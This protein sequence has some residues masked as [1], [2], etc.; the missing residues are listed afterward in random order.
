MNRVLAALTIA[1]ACLAPAASPAQTPPALTVSGE[2]RVA[3]A[4][5]LAALRVGVSAEADEA[6]EAVAQMSGRM[7]AI[8][9]QLSRNG[10]PEED[11]RTTTLSVYAIDGASS[12]RD[13]SAARRFVARSD[14]VIETTEL[15]R[16]GT[17][18]DLLVSDGANEVGGIRFDL[19]D[20]GPALDRARRAAVADAMATAETLADAAGV[21][22]GPILSIR[23]GGMSGGPAPMMEMAA[24]R[25]SGVPV[26]AGDIEITASV[27]IDFAIGAGSP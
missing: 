22:L 6:S 20:R 3:V 19:Q 18:L 27:V 25:G 26:A 23:Q 5:D 12:S 7:T 10:I 15:D 4:P 24:V 9:E 13:G 16:L 2:G 17:L 11:I 8:L 21:D 14:V 1:A